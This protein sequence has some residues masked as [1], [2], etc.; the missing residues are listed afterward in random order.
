MMAA[1]RKMNEFKD[2]ILARI[3]EKFN[4][5]KGC[6]RY[7]LLICFVSLKVGICETRKNVFYY[8]SKVFFILEIIKF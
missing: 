5:L 2:E 6:V 7:I 3:D 4:S 8:T 1:A